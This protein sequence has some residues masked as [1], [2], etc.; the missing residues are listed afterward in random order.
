MR[1]IIATPLH[2]LTSS[3]LHTFSVIY[4]TS[5]CVCVLRL[6]WR[7]GATT[8]S[9]R[10]GSTCSNGFSSCQATTSDGPSGITFRRPWTSHADCE[11]SPA[12][13]DRCSRS[14]AVETPLHKRAGH[15]KARF[16]LKMLHWIQLFIYFN[17]LIFLYFICYLL[18]S[19]LF[20]IEIR[21]WVC[22]KAENIAVY[23]QSIMI[24]VLAPDRQRPLWV[25]LSSLVNLISDSRSK[26]TVQPGQTILGRRP[27]LLLKHSSIVQLNSQL[28][29]WSRLI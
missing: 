4:N 14:S 19:L 6:A 26:L 2:C 10:S 20:Y 21:E 17:V 27:S 15:Q 22:T 12:A 25:K 18:F 8:W 5:V 1:T 3:N 13:S 23:R 16:C 11:F 7:W 28:V 24:I 9:G 29:K